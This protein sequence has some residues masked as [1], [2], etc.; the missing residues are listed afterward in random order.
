MRALAST[1]LA[2]ATCIVMTGCDD[3][4]SPDGGGGAEV[5]GG[6]DGGGG[7]AEPG[8]GEACVADSCSEDQFCD[9]PYH[10]CGGHSEDGST[11]GSCALRSIECP[12]GVPVCG[13]DGQVYADAC[14]AYEA[15]L[16]IHGREPGD[17]AC[18][19]ELTP[20]GRFACGP[21]YCDASTS[22]CF[23]GIGDTEDLDVECRELPDDCAGV[24]SCDC[25]PANSL[26]ECELVEGNGV[27]G[28]SI[29]EDLF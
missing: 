25:V 8:L 21:W 16:D 3:G 26:A 17:S 5:G 24:G 14:L 4:S 6:A 20:A 7:S 29:T 10:R 19:D 1:I 15:G 9:D 12:Q 27:T 23:Y 11:F 13:C 28:V 18:G 22:Y 2:L